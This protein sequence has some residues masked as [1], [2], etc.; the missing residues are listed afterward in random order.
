M[1][2]NL[3]KT[4]KKFQ[5]SDGCVNQSQIDLRCPDIEIVKHLHHSTNN[6]NRLTN[7]KN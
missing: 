7:T 3:I 5:G 6:L 2:P 4:K 1:N